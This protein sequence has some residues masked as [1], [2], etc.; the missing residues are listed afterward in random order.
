MNINLKVLNKII[1]K[2]KLNI[3]KSLWLLQLYKN[4]HNLLNNYDSIINRIVAIIKLS[5]I[6]YIRKIKGLLYNIM[7]TNI[8]GTKI[9]IDIMES[10]LRSN[11]IS[12]ISKYYASCLEDSTRNA[13]TYNR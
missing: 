4:N 10:L 6:C 2:S 8:S 1:Y 11:N 5:N 9:I 3:K 12:F 13:G 7:I